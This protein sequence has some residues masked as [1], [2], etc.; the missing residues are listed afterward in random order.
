[1]RKWKNEK[2]N[3][4]EEITNKHDEIKRLLKHNLSQER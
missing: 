2:D 1:M 4:K 3:S